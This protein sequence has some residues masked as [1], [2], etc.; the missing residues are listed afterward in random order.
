LHRMLGARSTGLELRPP[1]EDTCATPAL[2]E[3][4]P[5]RWSRYVREFG[6]GLPS[7]R[8]R[9]GRR[10][11]ARTAAAEVAHGRLPRDRTLAELEAAIH[12]G[13]GGGFPD[14]ADWLITVTRRLSEVGA[15]VIEP[16]TL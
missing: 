8:L 16:D 15:P 10:W 5:E 12:F 3:V 6:R 13:A 11:D 2:V 14:P 4:A 7:G 9:F 1:A